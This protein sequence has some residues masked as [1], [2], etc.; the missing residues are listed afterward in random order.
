MTVHTW[1]LFVAAVF[2]L[3]GTP[4]PNMLHILWRSVD[5]G[6]KHSITAMA[7]C[8]T[9]LVAVLAASA[10]GLTTLLLALP[11]SFEVLRYVGVAYLLYLGIKAWRSDIALVDVGNGQLPPAISKVAL[12]RG[13]F[14]IG[15][16][17][18][19][20]ILFASA[21]LPQF[22]DPAEPQAPQFAILVASFAA[23]EC[24]WYVIYAAG[25]RSL[26]RHLARPSTKRI[27]NR[28]TG[29]IFFGFGA[30]LLKAK[31]A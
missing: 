10:A 11:G 14:A 28:V 13:G 7:G 4:G 9:A 29:A 2:L 19:K 23:V 27:F 6:M 16:S 18:P 25:G 21:F 26:S 8:L 12:F 30:I 31:P 5:K 3:C 1:W 20:L 17:N 24:F 22:V 15:I